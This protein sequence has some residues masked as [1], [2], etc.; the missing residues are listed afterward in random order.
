MDEYN[1]RKADGDP[2]P[3]IHAIALGPDADQKA[4]EQLA[5]S[6]GGTYH[7]AGESIGGLARLGEGILNNEL[8]EIYRV[9]GETIT[10]QQQVYAQ[11]DILL[12]GALD[13]HLVQVDGS[14]SE[15][16][17]TFNWVPNGI[18]PSTLK[19]K[20]PDGTFEGVADLFDARHV[21]WRIP[22]PMPGEWE[23]RIG[24]TIPGRAEEG[25]DDFRSSSSPQETTEVVTTG[26][27]AAYLAEAALRSD[28]R[29]DVF[30]G[31][32]VAERLIGKPMPIFVSLSDSQPLTGATVTAKINDPT[33]I[34]STI[35][36]YDDGQHGDGAAADGFYGRTFYQTSK[37][38]SYQVL[39]TAEGTS[40]LN[41]EF[42]RRLRTSFYLADDNDRDEDRLPDWWEEEHGTDPSLPD[43]T[44]D[45]DKDNLN[46]AHEFQWGTHPLDPDTDNGGEGDGSEVFRGASPHN[47]MMTN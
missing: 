20:R 43:A 9:V 37:E 11:Q 1:A 46:N 10:L 3:R 2:V 7:F 28:I 39:V 4:M 42:K 23:M 12:P 15:A 26:L 22:T 25:S 13:I 17:F 16:I 24:H 45:P 19:L 31:L 44:D 36:L 21:M 5:S 41:G 32:P 27:N 35:T 34:I 30:L 47:P 8:A 18:A 6:T 33:G 29:M 40:P 38:G 14:A